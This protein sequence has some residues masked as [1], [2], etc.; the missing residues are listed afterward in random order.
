MITKR[1]K[2]GELA[3]LLDL[4]AHRITEL[5]KLRI[6][7]KPTDAG[8]DLVA[9]VKG[10]ITFL[11]STHGTLSDE[12]AR[13]TKA[14]ATLA[15]VKLRVQEG[16]LIE[17]LQVERDAFRVARVVRDAM[18]SIPDRLAALVTA[19]TDQANNHAVLTKEILAALK[20]VRL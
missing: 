10:Y 5:A 14:Q 2:R 12:R 20:G 15:E 9:S 1:C 7:P 8:Y 6:I 3:T 11:R 16:T 19:E 4:S 17:A 18:L 13:L